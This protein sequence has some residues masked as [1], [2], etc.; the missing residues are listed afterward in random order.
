MLLWIAVS[1]KI[2]FTP[3]FIV[4]YGEIRQLL[5]SKWVILQSP[6]MFRGASGGAIG[7]LET[8]LFSG[9]LCMAALYVGLREAW[10]TAPRTLVGPALTLLAL[11]LVLP[12]Q[13]F[14]IALIGAR[15][16]VA[17]ACLVLAG[18]KPTPAAPLRLALP[19]S[20]TVALLT[21]A[22]V[23]DVAM[24][25]QSCDVQYAEVRRAMATLPRGVTLSTVLEFDEPAPP[26]ACTNLSIYLQMAQLVT[27]D[28]SGYESDF[29]SR[30]TSVG[31][32]SGHV[33]EVGPMP[34]DKFT[35]APRSGY[36]LWIH[37]DHHRLV[38]P[39]LQLLR[40]GSFF[41][42]WQV[43]RKGRNPLLT[44]PTAPVGRSRTAGVAASGL[45]PS[46]GQ[47]RV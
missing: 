27:I 10:L 14:G 22:H 40:R 31:V 44:Y 18:L 6:F 34:A 47:R 29:Y 39:Y 17:V 3:A 11:T 45:H 7:D 23:A 9:A 24:L 46:G 30:G 25:M 4:D 38:P 19:V 16:P 28:R 41:D 5:Y 2:N 20:A 37:F 15:F 35:E 32:R 1:G 43:A 12:E 42:L 13:A 21:V 33:I 26:G 36:V 8:G